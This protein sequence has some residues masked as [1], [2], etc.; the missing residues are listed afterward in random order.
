MREHCA[1]ASASGRGRPQINLQLNPD[2]AVVCAVYF[3][4]NRIS[5]TVVDYAGQVLNHSSV[6]VMTQDSSLSEIR[7]ALVTHI[8]SALQATNRDTAHLARISVGF[9][10]VVDVEGST[11]LWTPII[12]QRNIPVQKWL[13]QRF[14]VPASVANDC[15]MIVRALH[16]R[17]PDRY[18]QNFACVLLAQGVGMGL[19]LRESVINGTQSSGMEFGHMK[20]IPNGALCRCGNRGCIEAYAGDYAV[21]RRASGACDQQQPPE[22]LENPDLDKILLAARQ[23]DKRAIEAIELA[24]A[25]IGT[26]IANLFALVDQFPIVLVG[27]GTA[28]FDLMEASL[29]A[30]L[31]TAPGTQNHQP[32][33]IACYLEEEP[34]V[35][36]GSVINALLAH[37]TEIAEQ[38]AA[39]EVYS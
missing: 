6:S 2:I 34:L 4:W 18:A 14:N 39:H 11:V 12:Q 28:N 3:Q 32:I 22:L 10:G 9:Q 1:S 15:D 33:E 19:H 5:A 16:W 37:D 7:T 23:G 31:S 17:E 30:S 35:L 26:G 21:H 24:G 36:E 29:R 8:E 27:R 20:F 13:Q 38:R 25:A